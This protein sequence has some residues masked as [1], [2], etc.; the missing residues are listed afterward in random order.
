MS[1]VHYYTLGVGVLLP[2][3]G[4]AFDKITFK[5]SMVNLHIFRS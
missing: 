5:I 2:C 1:T 3:F 4:G